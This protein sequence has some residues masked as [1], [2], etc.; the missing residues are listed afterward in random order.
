MTIARGQQQGSFTILIANKIFIA[1]LNPQLVL[2][3]WDACAAK[4]FAIVL[5]DAYMNI[6]TGECSVVINGA[7][8]DIPCLRKPKVRIEGGTK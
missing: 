4:N 2:A 6:R 1:Q 5:E 8:L 3:A 7:T